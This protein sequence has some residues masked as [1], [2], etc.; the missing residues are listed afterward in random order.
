MAAKRRWPSPEPAESRGTSVRV[1]DKAPASLDKQGIGHARLVAMMFA[2]IVRVVD[3]RADRV[4]AR[5]SWRTCIWNDRRS[6]P[7]LF[8]A[9]RSGIPLFAPD[10]VGEGSNNPS[11][12]G[13]RP[14]RFRPGKRRSDALC[15]TRIGE[16]LR[17]L[18]IDFPCG[19]ERRQAALRHE[20]IPDEIADKERVHEGQ[21]RS[22]L[23]WSCARRLWRAVSRLRP[24]FSSR[25][26]HRPAAGSKLC[27]AEACAKA[28]GRQSETNGRHAPTCKAGGAL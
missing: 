9:G 5:D 7:H 24:I 8:F 25:L 13:N 20:Q 17:R 26:D 22:I 6:S 16:C 1:A 14:A 21:R 11:D 3:C 15:A 28:A 18:E 2:F 12:G 4:D 23:R 10:M 19:L 27:R